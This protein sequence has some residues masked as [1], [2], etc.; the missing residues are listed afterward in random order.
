[1]GCSEPY[2]FNAS[3]TCEAQAQATAS[4]LHIH[5]EHLAQSPA[6]WHKT[7]PEQATAADEQ[8]QWRRT[9]LRGAIAAD[10]G[11]HLADPGRRSYTGR[12]AGGVFDACRKREPGVS[13]SA[14]PPPP[15]AQ[16]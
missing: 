8:D 3:A 16:R 13:A 5:R 9:A 14:H 11:Q 4:S 1:M 12:E 10:S 15:Q 7:I 6:R 2:A